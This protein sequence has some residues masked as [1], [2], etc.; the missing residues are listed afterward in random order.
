M[1]LL[2]QIF[3]KALSGEDGLIGGIS[4]AA[5][6][7]ITT[8]GEKQEFLNEI[9]SLANDKLKIMSEDRDSARKLQIAA[10]NQSDLFSKRFIYY[11][12][13]FIIF[14]ATGFGF[15]L[16]FVEVPTENK[17]LVEM[18]ADV[19]LFAGALSVIYFFFGSSQGGEKEKE[20]G[21]KMEEFLK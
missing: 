12:A 11:L 4:K 10:L 7:F 21:G 5:D 17:R 15:A 9:T 16:F 1:N 3:G 2:G 18:F 13:G 19:Y 20:S 6:R 8:K 14:A